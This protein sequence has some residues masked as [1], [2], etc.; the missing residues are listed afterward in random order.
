VSASH[1]AVPSSNFDR[2][3]K[4]IFFLGMELGEMV[5]QYFNR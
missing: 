3:K 1:T 2:V 4:F 5:E